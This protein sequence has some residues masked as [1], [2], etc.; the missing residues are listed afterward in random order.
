M[1]S[2]EYS[3]I[4]RGLKFYFLHIASVLL[5]RGAS[6]V[7]TDGVSV[8]V[9]EGDSVTLHTDVS[10][11]QQ[12]RIKWYFNDT[13]VAEI[14]GDLSKIC[15]NDQCHDDKERLRDGIRLDHQTGSLTITNIRN[16]DSGLYKLHIMNNISSIREKVFMV[17]VHGVPAAEIDTVKTK[18]VMEGESVTL[19]THMLK[20][21]NDFIAWYF[22]DI[23][24]IEINGHLRY[25]CT[26]VQCNKGTERFRDRLK[27][28][29]QTGSLTIMNTRIT[30]SGDYHLEIFSSNF[31]I[32]YIRSFSV[33]VNG[34]LGVL[35]DGGSVFVM[36]GDSVTLHTGVKKSQNDRIVWYF[37]DTFIAQINGNLKR[38]SSVT[39]RLVL[40]SQTGSLTITNITTTDSGVYELQVISSRISQKIFSVSVHDVPGAE[41]H[42]IKTMP[43]AEGESVTLDPGVIKK[44]NDLM[45]WYFNGM[46][47]AE[48]SG[49]LSFICPD[50]QC[51]EGTKRFR[52]RLK[53]DHQ[54]GSLTIM[55]I[56]NTD[57]GVYKLEINSTNSSIRRRRSSSISIRSFKSFSVAVIESG[58]S[59]AG[60]YACVG[61]FLLVSVAVSA[62]VIF[63]RHNDSTQPGQN[64]HHVEHSSPNMTEMPLMTVAN[65]SSPNR[66]ST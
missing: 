66:T 23:L 20:K 9:M 7:D 6:G 13:C 41:T 4:F 57:S 31:S 32:S 38:I 34:V 11:T 49:D 17:T 21:S 26:D 56:R 55:N 12:E 48:V 51:N 16:T 59:A 61:I 3:L 28:D 54:T 58:L 5:L 14:N 27:L 33:T 50:V 60:I 37:N 22:N 46:C 39:D 47:L 10:K 45:T 42:N 62:G 15:A 29:N 63:C 30:D 65:E 1:N 53:L 18:S 35:T 24:I 8:S 52:D 44:P 64:E 25:V 43:V 19:D 40:D 2:T 36:E